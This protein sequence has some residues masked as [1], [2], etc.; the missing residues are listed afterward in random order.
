MFRSQATRLSMSGLPTFSVIEQVYSPAPV[1]GSA[2]DLTAAQRTAAVTASSDYFIKRGWIT[3]PITNI[4]DP[5]TMAPERYQAVRAPVV[6]A[7]RGPGQ[8]AGRDELLPGQS[9]GR[10]RV[11][12]HAFQLRLDTDGAYGAHSVAAP[13]R[14][15]P[16]AG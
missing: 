8:G 10:R 16:G 7:L 11:V 5:A 15:A 14:L 6:Y 2:R 4:V 9:R 13:G 12:G 3:S 1:D